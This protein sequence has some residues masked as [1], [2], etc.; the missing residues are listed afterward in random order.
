MKEGSPRRGHARLGEPGDKECEHSSPPRRAS[1]RQT[2]PPK[3]RQATPRRAWDCSKAYVCGLFRVG[4]M[5]RFVIV[6][7]CF[8]GHYV[9]CLSVSLLG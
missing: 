7:A 3:Q 8:E 1:P 2:T 9:T 4:F 5:A 6:V